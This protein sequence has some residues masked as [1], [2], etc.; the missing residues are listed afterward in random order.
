MLERAVAH[1]QAGR[2]AEATALYEAVLAAQPDEPDALH[3]LGLVRRE[4]GRLEEALALIGRAAAL[5]PGQPLFQLNLGAVQRQIGRLQEAEA[6]LR[7]ALAL[8][9]GSVEAHLELG[10]TLLD[11]RDLD[12]AEAMLR[13]G[14]AL[15]PEHASTHFALAGL[16]LL[17]GRY[18]EGWAEYGWRLRMAEMTG[19]QPVPTVPRWD[20]SPLDGRTI[21]L[22][23]EQG[24]GDTIQFARYVPLVKARGGRVVLRCRPEIQ[25]LLGTLDGVDAT[26]APGQPLP[27]LDC[28]AALPDLPHLFGT[29]VETIPG[30]VPYLH[31][32]PERVRAW[33]ARLE[34][35]DASAPDGRIG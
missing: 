8:A 19:A 2:V 21:L 3:L 7:R 22:E 29:T 16:L 13:K 35:A 20:G 34:A 27:P 15:A 17:D 25:S 10:L 5:V 26:I 12:A 6:S 14:L 23:A 11:R 1:H 32:D 4:A 28:V 33:R 9:P 18:R 24:H 31:A 30:T